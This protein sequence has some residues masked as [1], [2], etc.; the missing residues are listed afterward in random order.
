M[1]P[2]YLEWHGPPPT[3]YLA[4]GEVHAWMALMPTSQQVILYLESLLSESEARIAAQF[5]TSD[6]QRRYVFAHAA[7]R[8]IIAHYL[9]MNP[10]SIVFAKGEFGKPYLPYH[11][12]LQ[13]NMSHSRDMVL[14]GLCHGS[15]VGIDVEYIQDSV[16]VLQLAE[17]AFSDSELASFCAIPSRSQA[18][19]FFAHWTRKEAYIKARGLGLSLPLNS[20]DV[21][22]RSEEASY[23][24]RA[25]SN[26]TALGKWYCRDLYPHPSYAGA[27]VVEGSLGSLMCWRWPDRVNHW[28]DT[29]A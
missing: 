17:H 15:A 10:R 20:F 25:A 22:L 3:L 21:P 5:R 12:T 2:S 24:S 9:D 11:P 4:A 27:V 29:S 14:I 19:A 18:I 8:S 28:S 16:D 23:P 6:S 7:L 13:F 1:V 26:V